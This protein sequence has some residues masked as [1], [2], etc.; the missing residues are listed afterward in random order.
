MTPA[1]FGADSGRLAIRGGGPLFDRDESFE[2]RPAGDG[3]CR[4]ETRID[5]LDGAYRLETRFD[6]DAQWLPRRAHGRASRSAVRGGEWTDVTIE[7][8]GDHARIVVRQ[9]AAAPV[10]TR[11]AMAPDWLVDFEPSA[12]PMWAM[13]HRYRAAGG[14]QA[15]RWVGRSL[16]RDLVL[17]GGTTELQATPGEPGAF[18]FVERLPM[19][20]GG[21]F[22]MDFRL[23]SD[24]AGRFQEFDL[25]MSSGGLVRGR[26]I[27]AAAGSSHS[28][29]APTSAPASTTGHAP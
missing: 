19:P 24:A 26:R 13:T 21:E 14:V 23:R 9:G 25:T 7:P 28:T 17:E 20:G 8:M 15:F 10:E 12:L 5:A 4:I 6:Y 2:I 29:A 22:S 3:G 27:D 1:A 18:T 11:V 16:L